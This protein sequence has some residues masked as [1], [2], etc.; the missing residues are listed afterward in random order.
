MGPRPRRGAR[1]TTRAEARRRT[2]KDDARSSS[3]GRE[4]YGEAVGAPVAILR[5]EAPCEAG[6]LGRLPRFEAGDLLGVLP[7]GDD[8]PRFYSLA[9]STRDGAVEICVRLRPGGLC[10]TFLHGL[11]DRRPDRGVRPRE[12]VVPPGRGAG[13][14]DPDR[15][16][17]R[18]RAA[19]RL[20]ARQ[21]RGPAG[22]PLLGRALARRPTSS[23]STNSPSRLAKRR[24]TTLRTAF[25]R[26][27]GDAAY[28]QD[29]VAADA[30]ALARS[31]PAGGADPRLRRT[32]HGAR[33]RRNARPRGPAA[34]PRPRHPQD[35]TDGISKMST[36]TLELTPARPARALSGPA[37]GARWSAVFYAGD[38]LDEGALARRLQEAVERGRTGDV[39]LA[40]G[41]RRRAPE[42]RAGR[43]LDAAAA[44]IS[45]G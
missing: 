4:M 40:A 39:A 27:P 30:P 37:M 33:R 15:R 34:R 43:R 26:A 10:S 35:P 22:S 11:R 31:H 19:R 21:R 12:P 24:L 41:F 38:D 28:V 42:P 5:F 8:M 16:G 45:S 36:E 44:E 3:I 6:R 20:R 32:R 14:A 17:R 7:P 25:S 29:R 23:T 9:S 1:C 2:P 13:A 18:D